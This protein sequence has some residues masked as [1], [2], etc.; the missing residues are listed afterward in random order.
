LRSTARLLALLLAG[1]AA[2]E[3]TRYEQELERTDAVAAHGVHNERLQQLMRRLGRL[4]GERL[5][6]A[7]DV[8]GARQRQVEEVEL[9]ARAMAG[10][11]AQIPEIAAGIELDEGEREEI[12]DRARAL[13]ERCLALAR[14]APGLSLG[15][16]TARLEEIDRTCNGCHEQFRPPEPRSG[17]DS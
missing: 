17:S 10:S 3:Q 9:I 14:D 2:P 1:C 7:L 13:E 5:P 11:A 6:K 12:V 8:N 4:E 16:M 15:E